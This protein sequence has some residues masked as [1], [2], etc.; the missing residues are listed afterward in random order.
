MRATNPKYAAHMKNPG[1]KYATHGSPGKEHGDS[2]QRTSIKCVIQGR[3]KDDVVITPEGYALRRPVRRPM[4]VEE[5]KRNKRMPKGKGKGKARP[6]TSA[7]EP[8]PPHCYG[9]LIEKSKAPVTKF[10]DV[11]RFVYND[12]TCAT[13]QPEMS[14]LKLE[15]AALQSEHHAS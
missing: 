14:S 9:G 4:S 3:A 8:E 13:S 10:S 1:M 5:A 2:R 7:N 12:V 11:K 15:H 6:M